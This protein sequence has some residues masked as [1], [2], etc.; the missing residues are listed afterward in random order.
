MLFKQ[1]DLV[2]LIEINKKYDED[3]LKYNK[4]LPRIGD[5]ATIIE[6]YTS[7]CLGYELECSDKNGITI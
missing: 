5:I 2:K 1:Y 3:Y 7:P 6:I 4:R